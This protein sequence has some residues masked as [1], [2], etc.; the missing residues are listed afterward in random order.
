M[1]NLLFVVLIISL[2][3]F[4]FNSGRVFA[5]NEGTTS[6]VTADDQQAQQ[7]VEDLSAALEAAKQE[8][9]SKGFSFATLKKILDLR[10]KLLAAIANDGAPPQRC[11]AV[12]DSSVQRLD[13]AISFL[14]KKGCTVNQRIMSRGKCAKFLNDPVK[15]QQC[16]A[17]EHG[18]KPKKPKH[19]MQTMEITSI[20]LS[21]G[22][23]AKFLNDPVK[24]QQCEAK[25]HGDGM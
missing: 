18:H 1:K 7:T 19:H 15:F 20:E 4:S 23:C 21:R 25:E 9:A 6:N 3:V 13:S 8:L 16:E 12:Y 22:K 2:S 24:F 17:K 11:N 10:N 14:G 5:E